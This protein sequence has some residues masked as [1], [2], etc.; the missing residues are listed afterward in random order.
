MQR[1]TIIY[2]DLQYFVLSDYYS[3]RNS[4]KSIKPE[5]NK[6]DFAKPKTLAISWVHLPV[7]SK[8][9]VALQGNPPP[10]P[11]YAAHRFAQRGFPRRLGPFR[12]A[13]TTLN[14]KLK[15]LPMFCLSF[16]IASFFKLPNMILK[17]KK[18]PSYV[19]R[20]CF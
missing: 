1:F 5:S 20:R 17:N 18:T 14:G 16:L 12:V 8:L 19:H 15:A 13:L 7:A 3:L 6:K 10:T 2:N 11:L 9:G 4:N